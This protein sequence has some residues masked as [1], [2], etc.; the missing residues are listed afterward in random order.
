REQIL[1]MFRVPPAVM[2]TT[3]DF[4]K[5]NS[6]AAM[7]SYQR[8]ALKPRLRRY[9]DALNRYVLPALG[10][11][12]LYLEFEDPVDKDRVTEQTLALNELKAGVIAVNEDR[13]RRDLDPL[14]DGDVYFVPTN[15]SIKEAL[16]SQPSP[17]ALQPGPSG[18]E[19]PEDEPEEES[20]EAEEPERS[21]LTAA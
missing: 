10:G 15:V 21:L 18:R 14:P 5:A 11:E 3:K 8:Q 16:E 7:V 13:E 4:N 19:P 2:G 12:G 20:E 17:P 1:A 6:E 9:E